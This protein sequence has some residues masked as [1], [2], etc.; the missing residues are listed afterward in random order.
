MCPR[1][2]ETA[3]TGSV[4]MMPSDALGS[5]R[6]IFSS[7]RCGMKGG[8]NDQAYAIGIGMGRWPVGRRERPQ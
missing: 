6:R 3:L 1:R 2:L 4:A 7:K 5:R 8:S